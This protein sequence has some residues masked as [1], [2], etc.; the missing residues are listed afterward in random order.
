VTHG[1]AVDYWTWIEW[2]TNADE[3]KR[4][5]LPVPEDPFTVERRRRDQSA[6]RVASG[7]EWWAHTRR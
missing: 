7:L 2:R 5:G 4:K 1:I 3:A 6:E